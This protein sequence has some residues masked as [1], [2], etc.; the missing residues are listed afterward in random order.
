[1]KLYGAVTIFLLFF[2]LK[3][4]EWSHEDTI[5]ASRLSLSRFNKITV[6]DTR[7]NVEQ[8]LGSP[9][10]REYVPKE[11]KEADVYCYARSW[12]AGYTA[13]VWFNDNKVEKKEFYYED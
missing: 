9:L 13:L 2:S 11:I 7:E 1:M 12:S 4:L 3:G 10:S 8:N 5:Y 6:G